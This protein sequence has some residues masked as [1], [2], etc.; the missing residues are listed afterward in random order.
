MGHETQY[1]AEFQGQHTLYLHMYIPLTSD[2]WH[3]SQG[4]V[5]VTN[6]TFHQLSLLQ[7]RGI[8]NKA[9]VRK[10]KKLLKHL[11][12]KALHAARH[13]VIHWSCGGVTLATV[14]VCLEAEPQDFPNMR[15][16]LAA[17]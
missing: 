8:S 14:Y 17:W 3:S 15:V 7:S 10:Q 6:Q 11:V 1:E 13:C 16:T 4:S 5:L 9:L 2:L 12:S